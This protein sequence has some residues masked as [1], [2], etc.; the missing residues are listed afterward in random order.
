[1]T[2]DFI[3]EGLRG[4][5]RVHDASRLE[6]DLVLEADVA[7]IGTGAG[8]GISA[9]V[10]AQAGFK[11]VLI[12]EGPLKSSKDFNLSEA[13]AYSDLYQECAGRKTK[14]K[15]IN[16]LQG[17]CVGG[18]T[19]VN[20]TSSFATPEPTLRHWTRD[21]GV[22]GFSA[23]EMKPWFDR[24]WER[25]NI[26]PWQVPPNANNDSIRRGAEKLNW[27]YGVMNRNIKNCANLGY[28]GMGCPINAKQSMLVTTIPSALQ[29]G[30]QLVTRARAERFTLKN[31]RID[32]LTCRAMNDRGTFPSGVTV[33]V[34]AKYFVCAAGAIGT[35]ALLLR[36]AVPDPYELVGKRTF[37]HP[38]NAVS[39]MMKE[40]TNPFYGA[41]QSLYSDQFLW[42]E[43]DSMGYK[44][45]VAPLHPLLTSTVIEGH[46]ENHHH[47]MQRL[48]HLQT[49]IALCRDG[50]HPGSQGG[51]VSL[52]A[53]QTPVLDYPISAYLWEAM[54][55]SY[56]SMA[57]LQFASGAE[58][59][60]P[61]HRAVTQPFS[62][63]KATK[64]AIA[65]LDM[66]P[67]LVRIFSAHVMGGCP[68]GEDPRQAVVDS[69]GR[70]FHLE[71]LS[72]IDGSIFPTSIGSNP[73]VS[74]YGASLKNVTILAERLKG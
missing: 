29:A 53:D 55:R 28:C 5:W 54:R 50:F 74:I 58:R 30:A 67:L 42:P 52:K 23:A 20:W 39:G 41:P 60:M 56:L 4:G 69:T 25:L 27:S 7:V 21:H 43:G 35:P 45:E 62:S 64:K 33:R 14:D 48:P 68:M 63:W 19:T 59:V 32:A 37:L 12:E 44:I 18:G 73:Q 17:R 71:N 70:F 72:I 34:R 24:V 46:G 9:E 11:L 65:E 6:K 49:M 3:A 31:G 10:L 16:I 47:F 61:H 51:R 57:E 36:S 22:K 15:A 40:P 2:K 26:I 8:G 13:D 38:V 1:M 66:K